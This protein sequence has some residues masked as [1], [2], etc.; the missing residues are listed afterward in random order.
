[1]V[2]GCSHVSR[3]FEREVRRCEKN[4]PDYKEAGTPSRLPTRLLHN[5]VSC[6]R[7]KLM[8]GGLVIPTS[9][10]GPAIALSMCTTNYSLETLLAQ[11][12]YAES[13]P[14]WPVAFTS[15]WADMH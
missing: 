14:R 12:V 13:V 1:M 7:L 8:K 5:Y 6:L 2:V 3:G 10:R 11:A 4:D 15:F 9:D